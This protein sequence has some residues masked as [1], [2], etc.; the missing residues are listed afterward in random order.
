M[1]IT[2][3]FLMFLANSQKMSKVKELNISYCKRVTENGVNSLL[4]SPYCKNLEILKVSGTPVIQSS[5][6][7]LLTKTQIK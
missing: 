1:Q 6:E 3:S 7:S 2:D 4:I 5:I